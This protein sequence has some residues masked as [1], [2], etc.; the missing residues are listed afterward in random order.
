MVVRME[1]SRQSLGTCLLFLTQ[2]KGGGSSI[3]SGEQVNL[4][5][6]SITFSP[7]VNSDLK[8]DMK[9]IFGIQSCNSHD[10]YLDLPTLVG[11]NKRKAFEE[12]REKVWSRIMKGL[13]WRVGVEKLLKMNAMPCHAM[14]WCPDSLKV[15]SSWN[16]RIHA[17]LFLT[18]LS[19]LQQI[20]S[21]GL[22][23]LQAIFQFEMAELL[24]L[25]EG[26]LLAKHHNLI[27]NNTEV[28]AAYVGIFVEL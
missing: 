16:S 22:P 21:A 28:D 17:G 5:K 10:K 19:L 9:D 27:I 15:T 23:F 25:R 12:I 2:G 13:R 11:R 4:Q 8:R 18:P 6:S 14:F 26:L 7:N 24:A 20:R 3:D 1:L